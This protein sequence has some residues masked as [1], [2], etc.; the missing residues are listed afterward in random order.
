[1]FAAANPSSKAEPV[2][3]KFAARSVVAPAKPVSTEFW[4]PVVAASTVLNL[5]STALKPA[6]VSVPTFLKA[7]SEAV[8]HGRR[9]IGI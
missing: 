5:V 2:A 3:L 6:A 8:Q 9:G 4:I 1:M 7:V